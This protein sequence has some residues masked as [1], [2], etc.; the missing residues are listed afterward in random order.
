MG[1]NH[2]QGREKRGDEAIKRTV[3]K[4]IEEQCTVQF[5]FLAVLLQQ[6]GIA[7]SEKEMENFR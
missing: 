7:L 4:L 6:A 1:A 3:F 5:Y 2:W